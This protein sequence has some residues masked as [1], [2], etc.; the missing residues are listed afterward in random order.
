VTYD[1]LEIVREGH[2]AIVWLSRPE[3]LNALSPDFMLKITEAALGF[4]D[5]V[6]TRVVIFAGRGKHFS[7]GADLKQG[8][9][10]FGKPVSL[11]QRRRATRFGPDMIRAILEINQITIAVLHGAALGGGCCIATAC[12]FRIGAVDAYCGY[13]EI[14]L[15]MNLQWRSLPLCVRL[16]G[17]SRAKRM[18][19]LGEKIDART[20]LSWG[21]LDE[22][23]EREQLMEKALQMALLYAQQPPVAAQMIKQSVNAVS[24]AMDT[25]LMHMD[26]DQWLLTSQSEDFLEGITAFLEKRKPVF[27]GN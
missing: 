15:G 3:K 6:E 19:I 7:A 24:S 10:E 22:M 8:Q 4:R 21:F 18:I 5:D 11:L 14:N 13:P 16:I 26:H 2:V 25:A 12:D 23:V 20:L 27:K 17:P 1:D 9:D